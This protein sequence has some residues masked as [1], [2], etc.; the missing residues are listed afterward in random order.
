[1][2]KQQIVYVR[3]NMCHW[4]IDFYWIDFGKNFGNW[5]T[6]DTMRTAQFD[7]LE[8]DTWNVR[9]IVCATNHMFDLSYTCYSLVW[10]T[11][12]WLLLV[13]QSVCST[14]ARS[15]HLFDKNCLNLTCSLK[16]CLTNCL[17]D[18]HE[19]ANCLFDKL[20]VW[21]FFCSTNCLFDIVF[22]RQIVCSTFFCSTNCLFGSS[23]FSSTNTL[24]QIIF[25]TF[26]SSTN[27]RG[28]IHKQSFENFLRFS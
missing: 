9:K 19:F 6:I 25:S 11:Y 28:R 4:I 7:N 20:F 21:H 18:G 26:T 22:V 23:L 2:R 15:K 17:F 16:V 24:H 12:I 13:R 3:N 1:M 27:I 8:F 10:R 5:N 14:S